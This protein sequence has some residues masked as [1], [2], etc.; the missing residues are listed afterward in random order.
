MPQPG[1][2]EIGGKRGLLMVITGDGKGKTTAAFGLA[3]RA[4]GHGLRVIVIQFMKGSRNYGEYIAT[5]EHLSGLVSVEQYGRDEFVVKGNPLQV[6]VDHA[7][8]GLARAREV[9]A[10][11]EF[12]LVVLDEINVAMDFGL[13]SWSEVEGLLAGRNS[14]VNVLLTGRYAPSP[15]VQMADQVSEVLDIKHHFADG[16]PAREGIEY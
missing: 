8:R 7:H 12:D 9:L 15:L 11:G 1:S 6:D 10:D 2:Q 14:A 13:L 4:A 5:R 3:L 16:I